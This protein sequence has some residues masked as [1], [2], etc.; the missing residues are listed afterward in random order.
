M[1]LSSVA[2]AQGTW[3]SDDIGAVGISGRSSEA[4]GTVE[5]VGSGGD[6]W[7]NADGFHFRHQSWTGD[8]EIVARVTHL[9]NTHAWAKVGVM[10]RE[11]SQANSRHA[12]MCFTPG[13]GTVF[14]HRSAT[15]GPSSS[16]A[17]SGASALP[18]WLK[19][20]R[21]G[22]TL[23]GF[24]STNGTAWAEAGTV[25]LTGLPA[26]ISAGLA[27]TSHV[28][29]VTSTARA[30][31]VS[32]SGSGT[33]DP[34]VPGAPVVTPKSS[35]SITSG[36]LYTYQIS[37]TNS[38]ASYSATGLPAGLTLNPNTG[39]IRGVCGGNGGTYT[40]TLRATNASGTGTAT[41]TMVVSGSGPIEMPNI[42][43]VLAP[44]AGT[45]R[46]GDTLTFKLRIT[47]Y[48]SPVF[49]TGRPRF[50]FTLGGSTRYAN[51]AWG[52][53]S[54]Y[55][56]YTYTI[57]TG[58][59]SATG[60]V[61]GDTVDLNGGT[62]QDIY[63][64]WC[65]LNMSSVT[66]PNV[67][68]EAAAAPV[69]APVLSTPDTT[70]GTFGQPFAFQ[71]TASNAPTSYSMLLAPTPT[72]PLG[73][74]IDSAT[75]LISGT[76][77]ASGNYT[78]TLGATNSAGTGTKT[79]TLRIP[80]IL[81]AI[82][83][84]AAGTY[85]EGDVL[86]I[87]LTFSNPTRI[88]GSPAIPILIGST[89]RHVTYAFGSERD[90][91]F[92]Y[93]VQA[94][95]VD[96]D[97]QINFG[98]AITLNGGTIKD[99]ES[100]ADYGTALPRNTFASGVIV[101]APGAAQPVI[102]SP[103]VASGTVGLPFSYTIT[104]TNSPTAYSATLLPAGLSVDTRSGVV[105]G[106][107][108]SA[109]AIIFTV[110]AT[111]NGGTASKSVQLT[112]APGD[113]PAWQTRDIGPVGASGSSSESGGTITIQASGADIWESYDEFHFRHQA[114]TGDGEIVA[115]VTGLGDTHPWAK[116]GLMFR[117]S[118]E[119]GARH[120]FACVSRAFGTALQYRGDINGETRTTSPSGSTVLPAWLKLTRSQNQFD[121]YS[122]PDG[123][124]WTWR[125][126]VTL[127]F[128][129]FGSTMQVGLAVTSH[130]DGVLNTATF[131]NVRISAATPPSGPPGT[132]SLSAHASSAH[133]V[134]LSWS[135]PDF[136]ETGFELERSTNGTTFTR[137]A[138]PAANVT[139]HLDTDVVA[140]TTYYYRIRSVNSFGASAYS[141]V[142]SVTTPAVTTPTTWDFADIG[143]VGLSG[144][145]SSGANT[146]TIS[147]AGHDIW[148][149][150]D[151][152]RFVYRQLNAD[153]V[154]EAQISSITHTNA[155][156]K[157]GVMIR[158][159]LSPDARNVFAFATPTMIA[160]QARAVTGG[161]TV[162]NTAAWTATPYWVR[163][164]RS[165]SRITAYSSPNGVTWTE[166]AAYDVAMTDTVYAGFAVTSHDKTQLNTAV[167]TD[168]F[169][170]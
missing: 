170:E 73:V 53:G 121:F 111:N 12:L 20:V 45:Y 84:P 23:T 26:T 145:N 74:S 72:R 34:G 46:V 27:L 39:E 109:G 8:G 87:R 54:E 41:Q 101:D 18:V 135:N 90:H 150:A 69:A 167:F 138:T 76:L 29:A 159:S 131:D 38:P 155:W 22:D 96:L 151:G 59:V 33:P 165:G 81:T 67:R 79:F 132:P 128:V 21:T 108:T 162:I 143:W 10:V 97:G 163:L 62:L 137:I 43:E 125:A 58:D 36:Y 142:Q 80:H 83:M 120:A 158:Q 61:T 68:C 103:E 110:Y 7:D 113:A 57:M 24:R 16:G 157:A 118:L 1:L 35:E 40:V 88:T 56:A 6:I 14:Q 42:R 117:E 32:L 95:D 9:E 168:P 107:P 122:S 86:N 94:G 92:T 154:V 49:V 129:P 152:F 147:G 44:D 134:G 136:T 77:Q 19:I 37:A 17:T 127:T 31:N 146:I 133:E 99:A 139:T 30:D 75:G 89:V 102:T 66:A 64:L 160:A 169:V 71:I 47:S 51:Y 25:T 48:Y 3:R 28:F 100:G 65:A 106:T 11:T 15:G 119:P 144:S 98:P 82:A 124:N 115:R 116:A 78:F 112:V 105:S 5:I 52:S 104:A 164:V 114:L 70:Q 2:L 13:N 153:I 149:N 130:S 126:G 141:G 140:S 123:A 4:A 60:I 55:H 161:S 63:P 50:A 166:I 85:R 156:A 93:T 91:T 148:D